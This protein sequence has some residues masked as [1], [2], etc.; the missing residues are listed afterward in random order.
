MKTKAA[1]LISEVCAPWVTNL[2]F[3]LVL[4][5]TSHAWPAAITAILGTSIMPM[6]AIRVLKLIGKVEGRH[7]QKREQRYIVFAAIFVLLGAALAGLWHLHT[8]RIIWVSV[9]SAV[10]FIATFAV[11]TRLWCK[12]SIHTGLWVC[13]T[14]FLAL[15]V[16]PLWWVALVVAPVIGW[17]RVVVKGHSWGEVGVGIIAGAAVTAVSYQLFLTSLIELA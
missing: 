9:L 12:A 6:A 13:V 4:G 2:W 3:F 15:T 8:P 16:S 17:S 10:M 1:F 11:V 14:I 7:V 5:A